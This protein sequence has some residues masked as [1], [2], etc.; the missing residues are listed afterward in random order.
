[1][2]ALLTADSFDSG[3][4][5]MKFPNGVM[6]IFMRGEV[7]NG[8]V[9]PI[10]FP[11]EFVDVNTTVV[12]TGNWESNILLT[13]VYKNGIYVNATNINNRDVCPFQ[14]IAIGRWK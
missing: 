13:N 5:Y 1:M 3:N 6:V 7:Y 10:E 12:I 4:N 14:L 2:N 8:N 11:V 9:Q